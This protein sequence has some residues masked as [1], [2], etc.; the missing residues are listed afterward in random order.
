MGKTSVDL[1]EN[2]RKRTEEPRNGAIAGKICESR[3]ESLFI[4]LSFVPR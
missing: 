3:R 1:R 2:E 4:I